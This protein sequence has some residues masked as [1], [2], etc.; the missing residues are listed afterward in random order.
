MTAGADL[1]ILDRLPLGVAVLCEGGV[2]YANPYSE[3]LLEVEA[4]ALSG[5][6]LP[7]DLGA[8]YGID[9]EV[10]GPEPR[11]LSTR[12]CP[13]EWGGA[14][15]WLIVFE[16][17]TQRRTQT[18][19]LEREREEARR[20]S[21]L[22]SAFLA[23]MSHEVRTP[24]N[25]VIGM[26]DLLL[27][28]ELDKQQSAYAEMVRDSGQSLLSLLNAILDFAKLDAGRMQVERVPMS[29]RDVIDRVLGPFELAAKERG[30]DFAIR[31]DEAVPN[32][33]RGDAIRIGQVLTN[34]VSNALKFTETGSVEV[35]VE[36]LRDSNDGVLLR[37]EVEDTGIGISDAAM[38]RVFQ[39]FSQAD[40]STTR[41][42][43]GTGLGL[44]I[45]RQLVELMGGNLQASSAPGRGTRFWFTLP[46]GRAAIRVPDRLAR[47][48]AQGPRVL[49]VE[50]NPV[51]QIVLG[52]LVERLG[53]T[54]SYAHN[55]AEAVETL[56]RHTYDLVLMDCQ[57]PVMDGYDAARAMRAA[58]AELPIIAVTASSVAD[59]R[60]AALASGMNDI[61]GKPIDANE[62]RKV[63][64]RVLRSG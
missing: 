19:E 12:S 13:V 18:H 32:A 6:P 48:P 11:I 20:E 28:T 57:M 8:D 51:N 27:D 22:K 17:V 25:G 36:F 21:E 59:E 42:Y 29:L 4:G 9:L 55:G 60:P 15:A 64:V 46:M 43:G 26:A 3:R 47:M 33:L 37:F 2:Q 61:L 23:N 53:C 7:L 35:S 30:L 50:D 34:L 41:R 45:S 44:A 16:D 63:L 14:R 31:I 40:P 56:H 52:R 39:P 5:L 62:L 24:L 58:G 38:A 10:G 49:V 54:V 1:E